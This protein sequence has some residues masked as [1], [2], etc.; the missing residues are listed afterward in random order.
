MFFHLFLL[1]ETGNGR[2]RVGAAAIREGEFD[3]LLALV[4][5][6][7]FLVRT[8][9]LLLRTTLARCGSLRLFGVHRTLVLVTLLAGLHVLL[10]GSA[11]IAIV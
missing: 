5:P 4:V 8:V 9:V 2:S 1:L 3:S 7:A 10:V 6:V 11:S